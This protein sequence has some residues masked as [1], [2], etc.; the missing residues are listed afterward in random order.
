MSADRIS[1]RYSR[2]D[3]PD[4]PG[5]TFME[6]KAKLEAPHKGF[7]LDLTLLAKVVIAFI[8]KLKSHVIKFLR[9][10]I[11]LNY[12]NLAMLALNAYVEDSKIKIKS[13]RNQTGM[14]EVPSSI[15]TGGNF[16]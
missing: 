16:V 9:L 7:I 6:Q 15:F 12:T 14:A 4:R 5:C 2:E 13:Y 3:V 1:D 10:E 11:F 8:R